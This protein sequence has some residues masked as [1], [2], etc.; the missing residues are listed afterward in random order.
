LLFVCL[1]VIF[2]YDLHQVYLSV[3]L[4][5]I[6]FFPPVLFRKQYIF[7]DNVSYFSFYNFIFRCKPIGLI[8]G[9]R[10]KVCLIIF[11]CLNFSN[12]QTPTRS[13]DLSKPSPTPKKVEPKKTDK[14]GSPVANNSKPKSAETSKIKS[15]PKPFAK[16]NPQDE[17]F[18]LETAQNISQD[19]YENEDL[20]VRRIAINALGK[21]AGTIVVIEPNTGKILSIVNQ[22]WAIRRSFKPCSTIKLVT[23]IAGLRENVIDS[24][25]NIRFSSFPVDLT[26]ATAYSNNSYFQSVGA[27]LG[28]RK[29]ISYARTLGLGESTGINSEGEVGGNLPDYKFGTDIYRIYS[30]GD[31]FEVTALQLGVVVSSITNGGK[32]IIPRIQNPQVQNASDIKFYRR[33]LDIS[34]E[35]FQHLIPGMIG[36]VNFGTAQNAFDGTMNVIGKTGSCIEDDS[37][38]GL[39]ASASSAINPKLAVIVITRGSNE[40]GKVA[41]EIAG[42]IYRGLR[43][44]LVNEFVAEQP[45]PRI[46]LETSVSLD[47]AQSKDSDDLGYFSGV[48]ASRKRRTPKGIVDEAEIPRYIEPKPREIIV[49]NSDNPQVLMPTQADPNSIRPRIVKKQKPEN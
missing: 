5:F 17:Q 35:V 45:R 15:T 11:V 46:K 7:F 18:R 31:G 6:L 33:Q 3:V 43:N 19:V 48:S 37:W 4:S 26:D 22:T 24:A 25:G 27:N 40:R 28:Y 42:N 30:H 1:N 49:D 44:R 8:A 20:E 2:C 13:R 12:A 36:A 21:H 32:L 41:A 39:F 23:A 16:P 47:T 14:K 34:P 38:N 9:W 10:L 29:M